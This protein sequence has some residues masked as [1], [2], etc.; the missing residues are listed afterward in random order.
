MVGTSGRPVKAASVECVIDHVSRKP[1]SRFRAT[2][3]AAPAPPAQPE[4]SRVPRIDSAWHDRSRCV[5]EHEISAKRSE[6]SHRP[7]TLRSIHVGLALSFGGIGGLTAG[8][9]VDLE[10]GAQ[11]L[12]PGTSAM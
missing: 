6:P 7:L 3:P 8:D 4:L 10:V 2:R 1:G 11:G 12:E 9:R 5:Y